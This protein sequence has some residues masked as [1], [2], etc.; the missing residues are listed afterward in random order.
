MAYEL[1]GYPEGATCDMPTEL[2]LQVLEARVS[3]TFGIRADAFQV[4]YEELP[5]GLVQSILDELVARGGDFPVVLVGDSVACADGVDLDA[6][7][8]FVA[9]VRRAS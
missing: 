5:T 4:P 6:V 3:E 8:A 1:F 2:R 9:G 7:L